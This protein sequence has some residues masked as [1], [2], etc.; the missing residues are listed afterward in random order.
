[1]LMRK[2]LLFYCCLVYA[3]CVHSQPVYSQGDRIVEQGRS[4]ISKPAIDTVAIKAWTSL[5]VSNAAISPDGRYVS[6]NIFNQPVGGRTLVI[7]SADGIWKRNLIGNSPIGF[8]L[9]SQQFLFTDKTADSLFFLSTGSESLRSVA[10]IITA[11]IVE[12]SNGEWLSYRLKRSPGILVLLNLVNGKE[13]RYEGVVSYRF[14]QNGSI[15]QLQRKEGEDNTLE[16]INIGSGQQTVIWSGTNGIGSVSLDKKARQLVF[17]L[18]EGQ[19]SDVYCVWYWKEGMTHPVL[20]AT[21]TSPGIEAGLQLQPDCSFSDNGR[22]INL[23]L[24]LPADIHKPIPGAVQVNIWNYKDKRL[25]SLQQGAI[26]LWKPR[27]GAVIR[28]DEQTGSRVVQLTQAGESQT[29]GSADFAVIRD[30]NPNSGED[31]RFWLMETPKYYLVSYKNG[32]RRELNSRE[33][34]NFFSTPSDYYLVY[35]NYKRRHYYSYEVGTGI[36]TNLTASLPAGQFIAERTLSRAA[37]KDSNQALLTEDIAGWLEDGT[38]MLVYDNYDIWLLDLSGIKKPVNLTH[39]YGAKSHIQFRLLDNNGGRTVLKHGQ[40]LLLTAFNK[41]TKYNGF[42]RFVLGKEADP[43]LLTMEPYTYYH[44]PGH[45]SAANSNINLFGFTEMKPL[46][47]VAARVWLVL[48]TTYDE[49]PNLFISTDLKS[50]RPLTDLAPQKVYNWLTAELVSWKQK[51]GEPSLGVLYKPEDFDPTRKYPLIISYYEQYSDRMYIYPRPFLLRSA[52]I[53]VTWFVSH[54]Y[55]VF[56]PDI[57]FTP[58]SDGPSVLNT[59]VS[60]A[61]YLSKRPYIDG[62][63]MA[64]AGHSFGGGLTNYL[65]THTNLFAAAFEGAGHSDKVSMSLQINGSGNSYLAQHEDRAADV[66]L[67]KDPQKWLQ[68]SPI[69]SINKVSTPLLIFHNKQDGSCLWTQGLELFIALRRLGKKCWMLEY[70]DEGHVLRKQQNH[71]DLTIRA[72]QFFDYYLKGMPPPKWMTEGVPF[73]LKGIENGLDLDTT[74]SR[75]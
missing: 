1:M 8:S 39:G 32:S 23:T 48:R 53:D 31:D 3:L 52:H 13:Q 70:D 10:G 42:Y 24:S 20:K 6:Y 73:K 35:Y 67:W 66:G 60:A 22:Y 62:K 19:V 25:Q 15:L 34:C 36:V 43:E 51:D 49:S 37:L 29:G 18:K 21:N 55:L 14:Y 46:K 69:M 64:I 9:D 4:R 26:R 30:K 71:I 58:G 50:Y 74:G 2:I 75:P 33:R 7:Q 59:V 28:A 72:T 16:L 65:V 27:F 47:A 5:D 56:T 57:K 61:E 45:F 11:E 38:G 12:G 63:R 17:T 54:G 44:D 41:Q 40:E 68:Q